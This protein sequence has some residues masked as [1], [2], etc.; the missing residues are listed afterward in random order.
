[1]RQFQN[2]QAIE[3]IQKAE[4][5]ETYVNEEVKDVEIWDDYMLELMTIAAGLRVQADDIEDGLNDK[6]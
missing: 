5:I 3:L 6:E 4:F 2:P 1:M